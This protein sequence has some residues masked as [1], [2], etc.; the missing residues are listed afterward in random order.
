[1][2]FSLPFTGAKFSAYFYMAMMIVGLL[3]IIPSATSQSLFAEGSYGERELKV[4]FKK[5]LKIISIIIIP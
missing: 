2:H 3:Y 4:H 1:M 5:A